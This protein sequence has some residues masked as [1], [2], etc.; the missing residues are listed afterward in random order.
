M[1]I[2]ISLKTLHWIVEWC[3]LNQ[4]N[5]L[6]SD[7]APARV[8]IL[9]FQTS[10]GLNTVMLRHDKPPAEVPGQQACCVPGFLSSPRHALW[11]SW[12]FAWVLP[13]DLHQKQLVLISLPAYALKHTEIRRFPSVHEDTGG[14]ADRDKYIFVRW[15]W[16]HT[17]KKQDTILISEQQSLWCKKWRF[18]SNLHCCW[19]YLIKSGIYGRYFSHVLLI[20]LS[21]V[22]R[23]LSRE[24]KTTG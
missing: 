21:R 23:T 18:K 1:L 3:G 24:S 4:G 2:C 5:C 9:S 10:H 7:R 19:I 6:F 20:D 11:L 15:K 13:N 17:R 16:G 22:R 14:D 12:C 8:C